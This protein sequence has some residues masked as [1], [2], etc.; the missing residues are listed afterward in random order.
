MECKGL[1]RGPTIALGPPSH[2]N[3][4]SP[5]LVAAGLMACRRPGARFGYEASVG[6]NE[7]RLA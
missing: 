5:N 1:C 7:H 3:V 2:R 6:D 4:P